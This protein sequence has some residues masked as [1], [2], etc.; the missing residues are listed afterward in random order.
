MIAERRTEEKDR[1]N[2]VPAYKGSVML[3]H[4]LFFQHPVHSLQ[5]RPFIRISLDTI[6][7]V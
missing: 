4:Y 1:A 5:L 2:V 7:F 6:S 3:H